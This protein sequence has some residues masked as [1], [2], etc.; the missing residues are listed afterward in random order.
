MSHNALVCVRMPETGP[1]EGPDVLSDEQI[2]LVR[3]EL[4]AIVSSSTFLGSKR[5]QEFLRLIVDHAL[6]GRTDY[7]RERMI[8]VEMFRRK[9]DYDTSNDAVVRVRANEV[10]RR[11]RQYYSELKSRPPVRLELPAGSYVPKFLWEQPETVARSPEELNPPISTQD[12]TAAT[13]AQTGKK[14]LLGDWRV[15]TGLGV[16]A[17]LTVIA[18]AQYVTGLRRLPSPGNIRTYICLASHLPHLNIALQEYEKD[19]ARNRTGVGGGCRRG[20]V[21][22]PRGEPG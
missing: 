14:R 13:P 9:L 7:L 2:Q 16:V 5:G 20:R 3:N 22:F 8:G 18:I 17:A 10:R 19:T 1:S 15:L 21:G 4:E 12:S 6:A 11:L